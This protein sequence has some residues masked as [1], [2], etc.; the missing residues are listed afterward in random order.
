MSTSVPILTGKLRLKDETGGTLKSLGSKFKSTFT[1]IGRI[2]AGVLARD[3]IRGLIN[4]GSEAI[5]LG[6]KLETLQAGFNKL[7]W[8]VD[9][10]NLSLTTL[11]DAVKGTVSD[12]DLLKTANNAL[13]LGLPVDRLNELFSAA[14]IVGAVMGRSTLDA[15]NDLAT[16][17]GRQ[18]RLILDNLGII[19]DVDVAYDEFAKTLGKTANEL[20][21]GERKTAFMNYAIKALTNR[22]ELLG[23][24][25]SELQITQE[26]LS[27]KWINMTTQIGTALIPAL[28]DIGTELLAIASTAGDV[29]TKISEGDWAGA[30]GIIQESFFVAVSLRDTRIAS[31]SMLE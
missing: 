27:A 23:G 18:S 3:V 14:Q 31:Q 2:A 4:V 24:T 15:V 13:A 20:S 11:R 5:Q 17:I 26:A 1:S 25:T 29:I 7:K 8:R 6:G 19:V 12:V 22:A 21:D 16:G 10:E 9:D 28:M 30:W